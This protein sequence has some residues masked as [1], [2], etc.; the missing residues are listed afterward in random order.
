M[1][2]EDFL[3]SINNNIMN[4]IKRNNIRYDFFLFLIIY[5]LIKYENLST[6]HY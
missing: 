6:H 4:K 3:L 2:K 5:Y 1:K